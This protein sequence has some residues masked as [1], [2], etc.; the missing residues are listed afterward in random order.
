MLVIA[1]PTAVGKTVISISVAKALDGEVISADSAAVYRG[2]NVGAAKI[3]PQDTQGV[4]HH[5]LDWADPATP[6]SVADFQLRAGRVIEDIL[7]RGRLPIIVGGTG[8]WIRALI[9]HYHLPEQASPGPLRAHLD[10]M[11]QQ[12]GFESLRRQLRVVDPQSYQAIDRHD[13]RRLV[14]ALEVFMTSGQVL[15][16]N[17][18]DSPYHAT[19][20]VLTRT[21][22]DLHERIR[23]RTQAMLD[24]GLVT[25]VKA[26]LAAGVPKTAQSFT[27]IGYKE[28]IDWLWG[29]LT[30]EERNRLIIRHTQQLAKRQLTWF[31]AEKDARWIDLSAWPVDAAIEKIVQSM[32]DH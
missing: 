11:G 28:T 8:L 17:T 1:G 5:G 29:R 20:W 2:L 14:R 10:A 13:H 22:S 21:V 3:R 6:F 16:R 30:D 25:E 24:Q 32:R 9:R 4:P 7:T 31:R 23:R 12:Y 26:L 18:S 15:P 19:Y 27:A